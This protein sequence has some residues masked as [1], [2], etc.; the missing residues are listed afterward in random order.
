MREY[1]FNDL[2]GFELPLGL[3]IGL[4]R[5]HEGGYRLWNTQCNACGSLRE[6]SAWNISRSTGL[7]PKCRSR[8][9]DHPI[10]DSTG[11]R[12]PEYVAWCGMRERCGYI[13]G[14]NT[15]ADKGIRVWEGWLGP[16][17]FKEF[18]DHI[19]KRPRDD[20]SLDRIE[21]NG[22]YTPGNVRWATKSQ[23]NSN[24][25]NNHIV[26]IDG[27]QKPLHHWCQDYGISPQAVSSRVVD[28]WPLEQAIIKPYRPKRP[29]I[30]VYYLELAD[31]VAKRGTCVR[32]EVGCVLADYSGFCISTGYN[33]VPSGITHCT[34]TPCAGAFAKSGE[35]LNLCCA[36]HAEMVAL[37]KCRDVSQV[38]TIYC[39]CSPCI[40]CTR[41]LLN[42][43]ATRI[44]FGEVYP[45]PEAKDI[46]EASGRAWV[47][48]GLES[49]IEPVYIDVK[50]IHNK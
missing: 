31:T 20:Y 15:Y 27:I 22:D 36:D 44:V 39:T 8:K 34:S 25:S 16:N 13:K 30:D 11:K 40:E 26:E 9:F 6:L 35:S 50:P 23:Q 47:H 49:V 32:R 1:A 12:T 2:T 24:K 37:A 19:G 4:S 38:K 14:R 41:R 17:G 48:L 28:G 43:S 7:C 5:M 29:D 42:T 3:V 18:V 46:W 10:M 33:A 21:N 45:H